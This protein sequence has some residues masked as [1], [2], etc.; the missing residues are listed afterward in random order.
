MNEVLAVILSMS[1]SGGIVII[2]LYF[3]LQL[4]GKKLCRQWQYYIWLIAIIRL[5]FPFAPQQN[6]MNGLFQ[7]AKLPFGSTESSSLLD[8]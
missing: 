5:L 3:V 2:M 8:L 6:L 1:L 4:F 7:S